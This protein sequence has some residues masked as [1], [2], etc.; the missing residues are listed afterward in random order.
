MEQEGRK[1]LSLFFNKKSFFRNFFLKITQPNL[2]CLDFLSLHIPGLT[3]IL[4][5]P[6][7]CPFSGREL[8]TTVEGC[9]GG[10]AT[11]ARTSRKYMVVGENVPVVPV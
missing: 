6:T 1:N 3:E 7:S 10:A 4:N 5:W 11:T 8:V 9:Y 2:D